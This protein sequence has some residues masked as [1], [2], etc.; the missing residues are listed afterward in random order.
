MRVGCFGGTFDPVHCGH[1]ILA[2]SCREALGLDLVRFVV[3]GAPPHKAARVH[4]TAADRLAMARLAIT[5]NPAFV[6][7]DRETRR[8]RLS[9]TID[10]V[11]EMRAE[12]PA[13]EL[14][15][16]IGADTLPELPAWR[17]AAALVDLVTIATASRPGS[18]PEVALRSLS[19]P[20]GPERVRRLR[21]HLVT[22]PLVG[23]SSTEVRARV[24]AGRSVRYLVPDGVARHLADTGLYR[25][26]LRSD[27]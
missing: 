7:D 10:T 14:V 1:L 3:A 26:A 4:A 13:D 2:E 24:A 21:E 8:T 17:E 5:G 9:F 18:D 6:V 22:M 12:S 23:I 27:A 20:F 16:L 11:R 19:A 15:W 25:G